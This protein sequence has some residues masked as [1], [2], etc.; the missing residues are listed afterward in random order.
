MKFF[1]CLLF[2]LHC[3]S[4]FSSTEI[5]FDPTMFYLGEGKENL[6]PQ[7]LKAAKLVSKQPDCL[8]VTDGAWGIAGQDI[9]VPG[10][11]GFMFRITCQVSDLPN[12]RADNFWISPKDLENPKAIFR[13]QKNRNDLYR[14]QCIK[15]YGSVEK[16]PTN[17]K[18]DN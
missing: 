15:K 3:V 16:C 11:K 6:M 8:E 18:L 14:I 17:G 9:L 13:Q 1:V 5:K 4:C 12:S 2:L 10:R 7:M